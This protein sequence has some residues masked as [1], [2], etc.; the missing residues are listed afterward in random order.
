M[1][2]FQ[3]IRTPTPSSRNIAGMMI[4]DD[5]E[6]EHHRALRLVVAIVSE[7]SMLL[8]LDQKAKAYSYMLGISA[9]LPSIQL[10]VR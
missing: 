3:G 4:R 6:H 8:L 10:H 1:K 7:L 5:G 2:A 9:S